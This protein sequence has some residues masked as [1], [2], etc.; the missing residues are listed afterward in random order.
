MCLG[1]LSK[2]YL[3]ALLPRRSASRY[4]LG[5][6]PSMRKCWVYGSE[7]FPGGWIALLRS[8]AACLYGRTIPEAAFG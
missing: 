1:A 7:A 2:P 8:A 5:A 3:D 4:G 6:S